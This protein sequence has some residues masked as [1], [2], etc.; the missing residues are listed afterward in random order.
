MRLMYDLHTHTVFSHGKGTIEDNVKAGIAAGLEAIGI[1]DHGPGHVTYG[2]K[3]KDIP[4]MRAEIDKL[5]PLY[6]TIKILL[7]IEA[8]IIE[9][10]GQLDLTEDE[11]SY[12]DYVNAGYHYGVFGTKPF[13]AARIHLGNLVWEI[14]KSKSGTGSDKPKKLK[15]LNTELAMKAIYEN[16]IRVLTHPGA[17]EDIFLKDVAIACQERGTLMEINNSHGFLSVKGLKEV[18]GTEVQFVIGSDA[19]RPYRIG[20]LDRAVRIAREA[21][22]D[23]SR[24]VNLEV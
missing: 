5:Q 23:L 15:L 10:S 24:I 21:G 6:P 22:L 9:A 1:S 8:N 3:R 19:H 17:K 14:G 4:V 13:T 16:K 18:I 12:L 7:G 20:M 11:M 2:V